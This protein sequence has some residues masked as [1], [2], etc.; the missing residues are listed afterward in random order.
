ML[1]FFT[2]GGDSCQSEEKANHS[3]EPILGLGVQQRFDSNVYW[4][5]E[6]RLANRQSWVTSL[7]PVVGLR[8]EKE[9]NHWELKYAPDITFYSDIPR[10]NY[11]RHKG[12]LHFHQELG[13]W[14]LN[15]DFKLFYTDGSRSSQTWNGQGG[16]PAVG[17]YEI[18][19]RRQNLF[20]QH[21]FQ[22][23]YNVDAFFMRAVYEGKIYDFM[24]RRSNEPGYQNFYD[25][26]DLNGGLDLGYQ[27]DQVNLEAYLGYRYGSQDQENRENFGETINYSN[28][29]H[30]VLMGFEGHPYSWLK[31]KLEIGPD[32]RDYEEGIFQ[33]SDGFGVH[34]FMKGS[35]VLMPS[36]FDRFSVQ[37][38]R[39]IMP[40][41]AGR[42]IFEDVKYTL[43]WEHDFGEN[44]CGLPLEA[45]SAGFYFTIYEN[46]FN[47]GK[48]WDRVYRPSLEFNYSFDAHWKLFLGYE[49]Q[50]SESEVSNTPAREYQRHIV[51]MGIKY[52]Y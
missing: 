41:S 40:G 26:N 14:Q 46:D 4:Y 51:T 49:Y 50:W 19:N 1:I 45:L 42:G 11:Q 30:R 34:T 10:E 52:T 37:W 25:R 21:L 28:Q 6:T 27:W 29:Y 2:S 9:V 13:Q 38:R 44:V 32:L 33:T 16:P 17:G 7:L 3:L 15:G 12:F 35:L 31:L 39:F 18:R 36:R 20:T 23:R 5:P 22:A 43:G 24:H 8:H 47:P 48:R